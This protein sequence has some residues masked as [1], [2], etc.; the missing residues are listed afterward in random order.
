MYFS[1]V[2]YILAILHTATTTATSTTTTTTATMVCTIDGNLKGRHCEFQLCIA[3]PGDKKRDAGALLLESG[4]HT[5]TCTRSRDISLH[6]RQSPWFLS[7]PSASPARSTSPSST[8]TRTH[9]QPSRIPSFKTLACTPGRQ[10]HRP[11][12]ARRQRQLPQGS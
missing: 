12:Q 11:R 1:F 8:V 5:H 7:G 9:T 3:K 6:I 2:Y 4:S 10:S